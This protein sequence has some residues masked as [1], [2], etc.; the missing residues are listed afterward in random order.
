MI[1]NEGC[2]QHT[3]HGKNQAAYWR[4]KCGGSL[5]RIQPARRGEAQRIAGPSTGA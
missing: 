1:V 3:S 2:T 4:K 5:R